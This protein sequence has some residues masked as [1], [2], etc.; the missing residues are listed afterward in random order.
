MKRGLVPTL[1]QLHETASVLHVP[2]A[3][4]DIRYA[5]YSRDPMDCRHAQAI[6]CMEQVRLGY[7]PPLLNARHAST[8]LPTLPSCARTTSSMTSLSRLGNMLCSVLEVRRMLLVIVLK[9]CQFGI[10]NSLHDDL[11]LLHPYLLRLCCLST[12]LSRRCIGS[13]QL[14][15]RTRA[16]LRS[17][18]CR[19]R[20]LW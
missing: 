15:A 17:C 19:W 5:H 12:R 16:F 8:A 6:Y 7:H 3:Q 9:G 20:S 13:S 1:G 10:G 14:P 18:I 11:I 2:K 4:D